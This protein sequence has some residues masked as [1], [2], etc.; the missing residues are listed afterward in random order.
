MGEWGN[1]NFFIYKHNIGSPRKSL[2]LA[3]D[4]MECMGNVPLITS[5]HVK[6]IYE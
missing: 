3:H 6:N 2:I 4:V 5:I 1:T